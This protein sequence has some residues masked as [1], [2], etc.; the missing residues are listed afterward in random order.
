MTSR[1]HSHG[2]PDTRATCSTVRPVGANAPL[3]SRFNWQAAVP[4]VG[5]C[6]ESHLAV[7]G[8]PWGIP[9]PSVRVLLG[10]FVPPPH[11]GPTCAKLPCSSAHCARSRAGSANAG[12]CTMMMRSRPVRRVRGDAILA[13]G[14][15]ALALGI[16]TLAHQAEPLQQLLSTLYHQLRDNAEPVV[17]F[18]LG[19]AL[20]TIFN[21]ALWHHVRRA[22]A[23]P[24]RAGGAPPARRW[25]GDR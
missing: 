25:R 14:I 2:A 12:T 23:S 16:L 17:G 1:T 15:L 21:L 10:F 3:I 7:T 24:R 13:L 18:T 20:L 19:L 4:G 22:Y 8:L 6:F 5:S 11:C 9:T